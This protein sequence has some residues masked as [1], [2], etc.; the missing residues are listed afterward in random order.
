VR[1]WNLPKNKNIHRDLQSAFKRF[2]GI[3]HINPTISGNKK[4]RD[5]VCKGFAFVDLATDEAAAR[6]VHFS[7]LL[8]LLFQ[9][10]NCMVHAIYI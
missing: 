5:P 2:R 4:T 6:C 1:L 8:G 7:L 10:L 9:S 3:L